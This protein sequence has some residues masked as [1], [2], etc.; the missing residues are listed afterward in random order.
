MITLPKPRVPRLT[1]E[2]LEAGLVRVID[3]IRTGTRGPL[4]ALPM[5][6]LA[7]SVGLL[8]VA[9]ADTF[10]RLS[11]IGPTLL[12]WAGLLL[13]L[14]PAAARLLMR[15]VSRRERVWALLLLGL[16]VY[17]VKVLHSP[18]SFT[19]FDEL[20]HWA[21]LQ[22]IGAT[23]RLFTPNNILLASP[24]YPGLEVVT[25]I[26]VRAGMT[27]WEAGVLV[28]GAAR[29][30][31]VLVL[32]LLYERAAGTE[33]AR[34]ASVATLVYAANPSFLFFDAQFAYE[35]LA[36]PLALFVVW[37]VA[38]RE[39]SPIPADELPGSRSI[40]RFG[41]RP[42][43]TSRAGGSLSVPYLAKTTSV[44]RLRS[45][46]LSPRTALASASA[47]G[48]TGAASVNQVSLP[49]TPVATRVGGRSSARAA[50]TRASESGVAMTICLLLATAAVVVTH[51]VT[52][53]ALTAFLV[54]WSVVGIFQRRRGGTGAPGVAGPAVVA[55][56][57]T[58]AW[59]LYVASVTVGYLAPAFAGALEQVLNLIAGE[60]GGRAL[61]NGAAGG[62]APGWERVIAFGSV[63]LVLLALPI[64]LVGLWRRFRRESL[65][66][67]LG[68]TALLY[69][70]TL[71]AR[72][73]DLG[74]EIAARSSAFVFLGVGFVVAIALV[75]L[76]DR[77][78]DR[79]ALARVRGQS[80]SGRFA[81]PALGVA[82]VVVLVGGAI[83]AVPNWARM[84]GSYLV[85]ADP[86]SIDAR[87]IAASSWTMSELGPA[88]R[89][90][91]DRI[92]RTLLSTWGRQHALA[93]VGDQLDVK[94]PFLETT[95]S[96]RGLA[97]LRRGGTEYVLA[98]VRLSTSLPYVGVYVERGETVE[99]GPWTAPLPIAALQKWAEVAGAYRVYDDGFI[100]I[101]DVRKLTNAR[102]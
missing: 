36:L 71:V 64:G 87:G 5:L 37:L 84:P 93:A 30:L 63:A 66:V 12:W 100:Q 102:R 83:L 13:I 18:S 82:V 77:I 21:T 38:R 59:M 17:G 20:H 88:N 25:D 81:R 45:A 58:I 31:L 92:N 53:A 52:S 61:F 22:D 72:F 98:D 29:L 40:A 65:A 27:A 11:I 51:H 33:H 1:R 55:L 2:Q 73:T 50:L 70:V 42:T 68:L 39:G 74:A 35:S 32:F 48:S 79:A 62:D 8:L 90:L 15:D 101:Y 26:L 14:C 54:V 80:G 3:E 4:G 19:L 67:T 75:G 16:A 23:G 60:T 43:V 34:L 78:T 91:S 24:Y 86:R 49:A 57:A 47:S 89:F 46:L 9:F 85:S 28:I 94:V 97:I 96:P 69:P 41:L 6:A 7:S 44:D 56:V 10:E 99:N 76:F 95:L